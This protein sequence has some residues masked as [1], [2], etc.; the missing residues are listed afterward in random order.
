M[1]LLQARQDF[2]IKTGRTDLMK[3]DGS[4]DNGVNNYIN[5]GIRY[6]DMLQDT[7]DT[8]RGYVKDIAVDAYTLDVQYLRSIIRVQV[9]DSNEKIYQLMQYHLKKSE[10]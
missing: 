7:P 9:T 1:T 5:A 10:K 6:L 3:G 8:L 4:T 2:V